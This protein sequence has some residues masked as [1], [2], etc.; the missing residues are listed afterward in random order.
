M[1]WVR[2]FL[3]ANAALQPMTSAV[4]R[5]LHLRGMHL[6]CTR[7][8]FE[9]QA[10]TVVFSREGRYTHNKRHSTYTFITLSSST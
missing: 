4:F 7:S 5:P 8:R 1:E 6:F 2:I 10:N 9:S 3:G